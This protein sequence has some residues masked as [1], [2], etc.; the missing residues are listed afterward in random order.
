MN[1]YEEAH[2]LAKAIKESNEFIQFNELKDKINENPNLSEIVKDYESKQFEMQAKIATG[3]LTAE[4]A[5]KEIIGL[6]QVLMKDPTTAMYLQAQVRFSVM[7]GDVYK[8]IGDAI[9]IGNLM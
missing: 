5:Q 1:V 4:D 6:S 7:M 9:G 2:N 8:I 3:E